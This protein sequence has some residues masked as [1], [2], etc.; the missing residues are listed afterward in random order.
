MRR[1]EFTGT[2][3]VFRFTLAQFLKSKSTIVTMVILVATVIVSMLIATTSMQGA[4]G[5]SPIHSVH[6]K[7][8]T[9]Y[10]VAAADLAAANPMFTGLQDAPEADAQAS[11]A[12]TSEGGVY[13][14]TAAGDFS[15][16]ELSALEYAALSAFNAARAGV[17]N[18]GYASAV[19][20]LDE[21]RAPAEES[22]DF[23]S[24]FT[25]SYAYSILVLVLVMFSTSYIVRAIIEEKTFNLVELLMVSIKPLALILGKILASM[26]L[27]LI[28][29]GVILLGVVGAALI[30]RFALGST[31][32]FEM[33]T[34]G[35]AIQ[36]LS[37]LNGFSLFAV[38]VSILLGYLAFSIIGGISGAACT[39]TEDMNTANMAVVLLA[40]FGYTA[41]NAFMG[42]ESYTA[43]VI[44]SLIP[45]VS[46]FSAPARYL[47][48]DIGLG[49]LLA[50]WAAQIVL[51]IA[52]A[53]FG[54]RVYAS[55]I[56]HRGN[57]VKFKHL[58]QLAK[59]G[60]RA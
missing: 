31:A 42:F 54:R 40:L 6:I 2:R 49:V 20:T 8:D 1:A 3:A 43:A 34:T 37:N 33:F 57:R 32:I 50:S 13:L 48:G 60:G 41:T 24:R 22:L 53:A 10:A 19:L 55:L 56:M 18:G 28:E 7:N 26:C 23:A 29:I 36:A 30:A 44:S 21:Y 25:I 51:I 52:L 46:V 58:F 17:P 5:D 45:F 38:V 47:M 39:R 27:V 15:P 16:S 4:Y 11:I 12:I 14:V 59:G 9:D 35:G